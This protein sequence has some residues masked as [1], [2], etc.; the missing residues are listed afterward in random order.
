[1][2][3]KD[4]ANRKSNQQNLGTIKSS[5][6][7]C[8]IMEFTN[9]DEVAVCN[10]ASIS[11]PRFVK[12]DKTFDYEKLHEITKVVT[13]NLNRV[14]DKNYYPVPEAEYSNKRNRP[15]GIGVQG[16]A[17]AFQM[18]KIT[19]ES[20][21]ADL[22][23][24]M[25]FETMY[26]A[27]CEM[28]HEIALVDGAYTTFPGSPMSQGKFQF[29]L[30][31]VTP[32]TT[33][34]D[35]NDLRTRIME[36]GIRNSLLLAPMPTASTSQILRNNES[37]EPYTSNVYAWRVLAGEFMCINPHLVDDLIAEGLWT[38]DIKNQLVAYNGSI[39]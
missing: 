36:N 28:S 35:W 7:C 22:V 25:I 20:E 10:L 30:W 37:F 16:L 5:N 23:N 4:H 21:E 13:H 17:D 1:M 11:L 34:Y 12:A 39:Q 32:A 24:R 9:K 3:Y 38:T 2:L 29:D 33:R 8:E 14:I 15:I 26:H 31:G 19:F 6:L 18:M 27:A